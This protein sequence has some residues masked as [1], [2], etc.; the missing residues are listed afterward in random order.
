MIV[1][2]W[3]YNS[4]AIESFNIYRSDNGPMDIENLPPVFAKVASNKR[5]F[6]DDTVKIGE[7]YHY[8]VAASE[9]GKEKYTEQLEMT[10]TGEN[11]FTPADAL[12]GILGYFINASNYGEKS[13]FELSASDDVSKM[14]DL[15][16]NN[17]IFAN[18][19]GY[20][21]AT[22]VDGALSFVQADRGLILY[23]NVFKT[24]NGARIFAI[25]KTP[26]QNGDWRSGYSMSYQLLGSWVGGNGDDLVLGFT[27]G[28]SVYLEPK[29]LSSNNLHISFPTSS[30]ALVELTI[31][32]NS[33]LL[34]VTNSA[35]VVAST[36]Y[37]NGGN[38]VRF[39]GIAGSR[40]NSKT[41]LNGQW[42]GGLVHSVFVA[43]G[44]ITEGNLNKTRAWFQKAFEV[45]VNG[46]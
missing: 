9:F 12:N 36:S 27:S 15:S 26:S 30:F 41:G 11:T 39:D 38:V 7:T 40:E 31:D 25:V 33:T 1:L 4:L 6:D 35:G 46:S 19:A 29:V 13:K 42:G 2:K 10:A 37:A 21:G 43:D 32:A 23:P 22:L 16:S 17:R 34:N 5:S 28:F 20:G 45:I 18:Q 14:Y 44:T 3:D 8:I 24:T